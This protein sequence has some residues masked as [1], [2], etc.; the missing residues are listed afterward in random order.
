[1]PGFRA[2]PYP[3]TLIFISSHSILYPQYRADPVFPA[4]E[5]DKFPPGYTGPT[6]YI[7]NSTRAGVLGCVDKYQI[8]ERLTGPCWSNNNISSIPQASKNRTAT[9][10]ENVATLLILAL[11]YS[12]SCG[13]VQFRQA[14]A[15]DAQLKIAH[16]QSL[17]LAER[18]W[19]VE[20][21]KMFQTSLARMQSNIYDIARGTAS[22]FEG[23]QN[24]LDPN[25]RGICELVQIPTPG[26]TNINFWGLIG[27]TLA[28]VLLWIYHLRGFIWKKILM[29]GR[30]WTWK[31]MAHLW[32]SRLRVGCWD[33]LS[34]YVLNPLS[35]SMPNCC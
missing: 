26:H 34:D 32:R 30:K 33:L 23:Y 1:L 27:T 8:C 21:E 6:Y 14:E 4:R 20:A 3:V 28:V 11:D 16:I 10:E 5:K 2:G 19:E 9:E 7:N 12:T 24:I 15:L 13:S 17:P 35:S 31:Q 25:Y 29:P 18:Q 22:N